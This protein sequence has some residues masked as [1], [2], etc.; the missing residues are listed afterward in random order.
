MV[1]GQ[2]VHYRIRHLFDDGLSGWLLMQVVTRGLYRVNE[3]G[4]QLSLNSHVNDHIPMLS[5]W[6][7]DSE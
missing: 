7:F 4:S 2:Q 3:V 6:D 1:C 5:V